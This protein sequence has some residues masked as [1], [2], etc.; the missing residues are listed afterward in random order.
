MLS[1]AGAVY[2]VIASTALSTIA[3]MVS[4]HLCVTEHQRRYLVTGIDG[5]T[6]Q[7][8]TKCDANDKHH[9][10]KQQFN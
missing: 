10:R 9:G 4:F 6:P 1:A 2:A 8:D 3:L 7:A 5:V